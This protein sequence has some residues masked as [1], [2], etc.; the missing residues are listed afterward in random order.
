MLDPT[1]FGILLLTV[2][3][4]HLVFAEALY[5]RAHKQEK[6][7][8][9]F[10]VSACFMTASTFILGRRFGAMG[11]VSGYL[12]INVV[13][14]LGFCTYIFFKYRRIWHAA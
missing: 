7:L 2:L 4:N 11:M 13:V 3:I 12:F 5:L 9:T 14:G 1:S 6:F 8:S 10:V